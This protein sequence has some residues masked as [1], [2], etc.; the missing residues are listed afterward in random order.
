MGSL[1]RVVVVDNGDEVGVSI[2]VVDDVEGAGIGIV[3]VGEEM[4]ST[5]LRSD[6]S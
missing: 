1:I 3:R 6:S 4:Q 5:N 2:L